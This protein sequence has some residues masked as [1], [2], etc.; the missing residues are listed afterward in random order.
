M[1]NSSLFAD[2][3]KI[4]LL[5][6][7]IMISGTFCIAFSNVGEVVKLYSVIATITNSDVNMYANF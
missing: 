2:V 7:A 6:D 5:G 1:N 3:G 4:P